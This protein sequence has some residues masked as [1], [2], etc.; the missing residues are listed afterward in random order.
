MRRVNE[1]ASC[2]LQSDLFAATWARDPE[3]PRK[4]LLTF[5]FVDNATRYNGSLSLHRVLGSP[6]YLPG[7]FVLAPQPLRDADRQA[8][9]AGR[10]PT[11]I[12][13]AAAG[14]LLRR[15]DE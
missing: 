12:L 7:E 15:G 5:D 6:R 2:A 13:P 10:P 8:F 1:D 4:G 14:R 3:G 9:D 11:T